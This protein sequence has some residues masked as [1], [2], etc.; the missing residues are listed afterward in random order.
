MKYFMHL[1]ETPVTAEATGKPVYAVRYTT[2]SETFA[3]DAEVDAAT[4]NLLKVAIEH[5]KNLAKA[6]IRSVLG[7]R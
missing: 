1:I 2:P 7:V 6:E 3:S 4:F 5:G